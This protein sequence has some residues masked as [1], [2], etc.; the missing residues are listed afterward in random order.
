M[1]MTG[2]DPQAGG[3]QAAVAAAGAQNIPVKT[4]GQTSIPVLD[5]V[6]AEAM[7]NAGTLNFP[8]IVQWADGSMEQF[9]GTGPKKKKSAPNTS[10]YP[11]L[12]DDGSYR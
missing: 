10:Q 11:D 8:H 1:S 4:V 2:L 7:L 12:R 9:G 3:W 6:I 5:S